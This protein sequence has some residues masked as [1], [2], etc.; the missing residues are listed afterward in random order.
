MSK[1][2]DPFAPPSA[3]AT[4]RPADQ[5]PEPQP[6]LEP[7]PQPQTGDRGSDRLRQ[8]HDQALPR[9]FEGTL[10]PGAT[11]T[12]A[13]GF[14]TGPGAQELTFEISPGLTAYD[15]HTWTGRLP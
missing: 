2:P 11:A 5:D 10:A 12:A 9:P 4:A 3:A 13:F 1:T 6:Q 14:L 7:Q 8:V 15:G